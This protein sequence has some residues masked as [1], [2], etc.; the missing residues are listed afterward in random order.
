MQGER[1]CGLWKGKT[2]RL[3]RLPAFVVS[4]V[5]QICRRAGNESAGGVESVG[6]L[7]REGGASGR[8]RGV[9]AFKARS[10]Q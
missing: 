1:H 5:G 8:M 3:P 9:G 10:C 4:A 2:Q 7:Q 6:D